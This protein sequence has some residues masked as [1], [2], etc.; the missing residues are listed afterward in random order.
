MWVARI[1]AGGDTAAAGEYDAILV[2]DVGI[3][4]RGQVQN[5]EAYTSQYIDHQIFDDPERG[6]VVAAR[7]NLA[8]HDGQH[9][10]LMH[11]CFNGGAAVLTDAYDFFG[12]AHRAGGDPAVVREAVLPTR[13]RQFECSCHVLQSAPIT[14]VAG[15]PSSIVFAAHYEADHPAASSPEDLSKL[16]G[17]GDAAPRDALGPCQDFTDTGGADRRPAPLAGLPLSPEQIE[18]EYGGPASRRHEERID[19]QPASFFVDRGSHVALRAKETG[20]DRRHAHLVKEGWAA[21]PG[22]ET[23]GSTAYASGV[24]AS[25]V[26]F[27]NTTFNKWLSVSR[28]PLNLDRFDGMRL[29]VRL[30]GDGPWR[31]LTTASAFAM[32]P[33]GCSW[34]YELGDGR[35]IRVHSGVTMGEQPALGIDVRPEGGPVDLRMTA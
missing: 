4:G 1:L 16:P 15:T 29:F 10:W 19:G 2:Q 33:S 27:G 32:T 14:A 11:A 22:G 8:Q 3:A 21:I 23:L 6:K 12:P 18:Q 25:H 35:R 26:F 34:L 30:G 17:F 5:N 20:M 28:D 13:R 31:P 9:P 24:F 7:Q